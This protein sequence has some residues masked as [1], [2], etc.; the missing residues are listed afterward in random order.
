[1]HLKDVKL[2]PGNEKA[3]TEIGKGLLDVVVFLKAL[4]R[5]GYVKRGMLAIEYEDH[6]EN[7]VPYVQECLAYMKNVIPTVNHSLT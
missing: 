2:L 6:P 5:H 1:V 4:R 7:P 3:F